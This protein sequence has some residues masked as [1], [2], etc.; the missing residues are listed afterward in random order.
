M[1]SDCEAFQGVLQYNKHQADILHRP[2]KMQKCCF[3]G[4]H[5]WLQLSYGK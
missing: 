5:F 3:E 2:L 1:C 4:K